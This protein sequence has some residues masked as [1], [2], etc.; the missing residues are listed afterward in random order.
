MHTTPTTPAVSTLLA[1]SDIHQPPPTDPASHTPPSPLPSIAPMPHV[2]T[3]AELGAVPSPWL[4]SSYIPRG[5]LTLLDGPSGSGKTQFLIDLAARV[6]SGQPLPDGSYGSHGSVIFISPHDPHL[7]HCLPSFSRAGADLSRIFTFS[8]TPDA[9]PIF[10]NHPLSNPNQPFGPQD[11]FHFFRF[12]DKDLDALAALVN[13]THCRLLII[14]S[15]STTLDEVPSVSERSIARLLHKLRVIASVHRTACI[16]VRSSDPRARVN[17][18]SPADKSPHLLANSPTTLSVL[19]DPLAPDHALLV[20][21]KHTFSAAAPVLRF[22][23]APDPERPFYS[24]FHWDGLSDLSPDDLATLPAAP[25]LAP[26]REHILRILQQQS[27]PTPTAIPD[28]LALLPHL[29]YELLRKTLQR[30]LRDHQ[31]VSPQRGLYALPTPSSISSIPDP[32]PLSPSTVPDAVSPPPVPLSE[33]SPLDPAS[34]INEDGVELQGDAVSPPSV[35]AALSPPPV[36]ASVS[37][38][39]APSH[40]P[41]HPVEIVRTL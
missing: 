22:H 16:L 18:L 9:A 21:G 4:W 30:M 40:S 33:S 6:S 38:S 25:T 7:Y 11:T 12:D 24:Q 14:D 15:W 2:A 36:P 37:L 34:S 35:P 13:R 23:I 41:D 28:L 10:W 19:P 31:L 26:T 5:S 20:P 17:R 8:I 39:T 32:D 1:L 29:S 27:D 3:L